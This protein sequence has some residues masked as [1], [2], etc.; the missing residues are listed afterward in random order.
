MSLKNSLSPPTPVSPGL[1]LSL[2]LALFLSLLLSLCLACRSL[3]VEL[4]V[5]LQ[6]GG[7]KRSCKRREEDEE[8]MSNPYLFVGDRWLESVEASQKSRKK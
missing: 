6:N 8:K 7:K 5:H 1:S 4:T 3:E 2:S